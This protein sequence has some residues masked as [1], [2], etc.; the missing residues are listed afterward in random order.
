[1]SFYHNVPMYTF[2]SLGV[3]FLLF[4]RRDDC[5]HQNT[6]AIQG[7]FIAVKPNWLEKSGIIK[8]KL[9]RFRS[10]STIYDWLKWDMNWGW[11]N[12]FRIRVLRIFDYLLMT[13]FKY[14]T[15]SVANVTQKSDWSVKLPTLVVAALKSSTQE[16]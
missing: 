7:N 16:Y 5:Y 8:W 4:P 1:M 3:W 11:L 10:I 15:N 14:F 9:H 12:V 2:R 13:L 6:N